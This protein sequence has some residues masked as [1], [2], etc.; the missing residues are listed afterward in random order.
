MTTEKTLREIKCCKEFV[1]PKELRMPR[2]RTT[3]GTHLFEGIRA[4]ALEILTQC[5]NYWKIACA[6]TTRK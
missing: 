1:G 5:S 6:T 4:S 2:P 3:S